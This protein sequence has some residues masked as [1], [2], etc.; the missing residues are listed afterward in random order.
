MV[1]TRIA[2]AG[3]IGKIGEMLAAALA[4]A[5]TTTCA[6]QFVA[7]VPGENH[8][9]F[10]GLSPNGRTLAVGEVSLYSEGISE[11]VAHVVGTYAIPR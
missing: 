1:E 3:H 7:G 5:L 10:R 2:E 11:P 4:M 6:P 9:M 8:V